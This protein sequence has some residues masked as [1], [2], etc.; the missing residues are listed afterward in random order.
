MWDGIEILKGTPSPLGLSF[1]GDQANIALFSQNATRVFLGLF[2]EKKEHPEKEIPLQRTGDVWH[3]AIKGLPPE[4]IF[5]AFRCEG[6][7]DEKKGLLFK[8]DRWLIDP[9]TKNGQSPLKEIKPFDWQGVSS[10][11]ILW[12]EIVLYEM[13][14]RGFTCHSSSGV[15]L[16]GT[17]L[18]LIEKIPHLKKL[19]I[20][21]VELMPIASFTEST[22]YFHPQTKKPLTNYW[23]YQTLHFFAPTQLYA[24]GDPIDEFKTMVRELHRNGIKVILDLVFNHTGEGDDKNCYINFRGI[25]NGVY[26]MLDPEG[27][28]RNFSG[29]GN[30]FNCNHPVVQDLILS[31]LRFWIEEMHV[32]GFRFD[33]AT[34]FMRDTNGNLTYDPSI[35]QAMTNDPVIGKALLIAEP[36]DAAGDI[37]VGFFAKKDPWKEWNS[38][39][40]DTVRR[41]IKGTDAE[42]PPFANV[43]SGS[44]VV[45]KTPLCSINFVAAHDGFSLRDLVSYNQKHNEDNGEKNRDGVVQNYSWNCGAEGLTQDGKIVELRERQMRNFLLALF[46]SQGIPMMVMGDEYG[47]TR[48][49]NNNPYSQDNEVNWF[50]WNELEK[51]KKIFDF[52]S[53]LIA[54]RKQYPQLRHNNFF[55]DKDVEWHGTEPNKP[56]WASHSR[57]VA[58][59]IKGSPPLYVAFN[60]SDKPLKVSLPPNAGWQ[61]VVNTAE[62]WKFNL[63]GP[64]LSFI[65]LVPYSALLA[66]GK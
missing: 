14:V 54:F 29:C 8:G 30:T 52:T 15:K 20:N 34:V 27:K 55:T 38:H 63:D 36:W 25:D 59:M 65:E 42:A 2:A 45:Y 22:F 47:H 33:S 13:H 16:P 19:G 18:G 66:R 26:Y 61:L 32:D 17:Y 43:L 50:L 4:A 21:A 39:Y 12:E 6:P 10:P 23:G 35:V 31:N 58:L 57:F 28:Y 60:A 44:N 46:L 40:R 56:D 7:Y 48:Q 51:N 64:Q 9:Y 3:A 1:Q 11:Q 49:G 5:Y 62:D 24:A 41:F 37:Q 53:Q